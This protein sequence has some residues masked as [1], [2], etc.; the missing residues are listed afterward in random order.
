MELVIPRHALFEF[1]PSCLLMTHLP[2]YRI[3]YHH[4]QG[5]VER[6]TYKSLADFLG[7]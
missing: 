5:V 3:L 7:R 6:K 4:N 1:F 2:G